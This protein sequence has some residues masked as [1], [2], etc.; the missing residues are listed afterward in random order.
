MGVDRVTDHL[1]EGPGA[2]PGDLGH[3]QIPA[4]G[5]GDR[6]EESVPREMRVEAVREGLRLVGSNPQGWP[7]E[8]E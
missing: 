5:L 1:V 2:E 6:E 8:Q 3:P 7:G 4:V